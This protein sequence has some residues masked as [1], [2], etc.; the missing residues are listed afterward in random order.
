MRFRNRKSS[1]KQCENSDK[2]QVTLKP[3]LQ[4]LNCPDMPWERVGIDLMG[5]ILYQE[6]QVYLMVVVDH[7][8]KWPEIKVNRKAETHDIVTFLDSVFT[9]EGISKTLVSDNGSQ[10]T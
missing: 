5:P 10:F 9:R 2:S 7:F 8:S 6:E 1:K 3:P 4:L